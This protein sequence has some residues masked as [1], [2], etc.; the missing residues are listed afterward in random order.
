MKKKIRIVLAQLDFCVGDIVGNTKKI[1]EA[2][3]TARDTLSAD[4]ILFPELSITGYSPEDA[5]FRADFI[6]AA[7]NALDEITDKIRGIYCIIGHPGKSSAGLHNQC[8]VIY[9]GKMLGTYGKKYL[10]NSGVFDECRYF[11]PENHVCVIP[12]H[13]IPVGILI[14]EDI[15]HINPIKDTVKQGAKIIAVIN[16]SPFEIDKNS[17]REA[18]LAKRAHSQNVPILYVNCMGGQDELIFDG[19]SMVV[20][21]EGNICQHAGFFNEILFPVDIEITE[22]KVLIPTIPFSLPREEEKIYN[23]LVLGVRDYLRKNHFSG[24]LIGVSGGIDSALTL[25]IAIDALGKDNVTAVVMP[26]R[27]TSQQSLDDAEALIKNAGVKTKNISIELTYT[28]FLN[29]LS[30]YFSESNSSAIAKENLQARCRGMMLMALSNA[31]GHIVLTT[32]NRSEMAVG[33]TTLYGDMAGGL[34]VLKDI[35]KLLV[36]CLARYRNE[37]NAIIPETILTRAPTAELAPNQKDEDSLPPYSILDRILELYIDEEKSI[38]EIIAFG[39][40]R[41]TV[42]HIIK[43]IQKSQ[44][45]RQQAPLGIRI[46]HKAFGKD[47]R[48]PITYSFKG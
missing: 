16:A 47:R 20:D 46:H 7:K 23:A 40:E 43:L 21:S 27:Y 31:S 39:F 36:Y 28:H 11:F 4:V 29:T 33:Y 1:I 8:S 12:I 5:L 24:A 9:N 14:C 22:T 41:N 13:G 15:W 26:S 38:D 34:S 37:I 30:P 35:P 10:P 17:R 19:G 44:H 48:Y 3:N 45:K 25:A 6:G 18:L 32:G 42:T 2:A